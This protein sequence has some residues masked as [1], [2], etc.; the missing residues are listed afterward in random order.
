MCKKGHKPPRI[1]EIVVLANLE[2]RFLS[3]AHLEQGI[4]LHIS[5]PV[6]DWRQVGLKSD[7]VCTAYCCANK[8]SEL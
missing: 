1:W 4:P 2:G 5:F 3:F 6:R 7:G 8:F